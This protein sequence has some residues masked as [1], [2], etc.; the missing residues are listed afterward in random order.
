MAIQLDSNN[1]WRTNADQSISYPDSGNE[2]SL[3]LEDSSFWFK[4]RNNIILDVFHQHYQG[5]DILDV[6]GGN[7]F[8]I[9]FLQ[10]QFPNATGILA[11]PGYKGCINAKNRGVKE[12]YNTTFQAFPFDRYNIRAITL[13]DVVEHIED[14]VLFLK[15]LKEKMPSDA[16]IY[17]TVPSHNYLWSSVDP[18]GG[19]FR[20]YNKKMAHQLAKDAGFE[21]VYFSYFFRYLLPF[22]LFLRAIPYRLGFRKSDEKLLK[23]ENNQHNPGNTTLKIFNWLERKERKKIQSGG[24]IS[25]G[26]S[27]FIVLRPR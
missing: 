21:L 25:N 2:N 12:V 26:A 17:I 8:Q 19:H 4:H 6:G 5:G 14:D 1:I 27:C 15:E 20:R 23:D 16:L 18:F 7:G 10:D 11:E 3:K 9:K 13:L 22:S 24:S